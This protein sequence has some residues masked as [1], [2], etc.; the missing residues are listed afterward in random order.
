[1]TLRVIDLAQLDAGWRPLV[2]H[3]LSSAAGV[4][5]LEFLDRECAANKTI[6][7]PRPLRALELTPFESVRA[8]ILG[9]DPYHGAGQA[10]GLAFSVPDGVRV[11]P[12]LANIF[13]ELRADL[14]CALPASGNLERWAR[15][16][17][18]LTNA[19]FT[20]EH[21][22][23]GSHAGAG[24]EHLTRAIVDTLACD[25][26]PKVFLLWG[27][28]AQA[29]AP[30]IAAAGCA[31]RVLTSNHPSPLSARRPPQ[32]YLGCRHFSKTNEFLVA[33]GRGVIR[34]CER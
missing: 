24:W 2:E 31:H 29:F 10:H 5:L 6:Y 4:R 8:V 30:A 32:P 20:V 15:E 34:W 19:V 1:M 33:R 23:A 12:S 21:G 14:G 22:R 16:G 25:A 27:A 9:Q 11:P 13:A 7:P 3:F 18:L 28:Q 17:V 26:N